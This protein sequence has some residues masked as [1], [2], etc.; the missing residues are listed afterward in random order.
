[1]KCHTLGRVLTVVGLVGAFGA[2]IVCPPVANAD[3]VTLSGVSACAC[4]AVPDSW[5]VTW[6]LTNERTDQAVTVTG[7]SRLVFPIGTSV[8]PGAS[9]Q[10]TE[11]V[12]KPG[13]VPLSVDELWSDQTAGTAAADVL[14]AGTCSATT[15][16]TA[17]TV[18]TTHP[19]PTASPVPTTHPTPTA[20]PVPTTHPT[21]TMHLVPTMPPVSTQTTLP[22]LLIHAV[23]PSPTP[24]PMV[25]KSMSVISRQA[26]RAGTPTD[27][28][29]STGAA[30]RRLSV[31]AVALG[32]AGTLVL[33]ACRRRRG[34]RV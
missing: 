26:T 18:P 8:A 16:T 23:I 31:I 1:M 7:E 10:A 3:T 6:T 5:T 30:A 19:A 34:R 24:S 13:D 28:L 15:P 14:V 25:D 22:R 11:S 32:A 17:P 4:A 27:S 12:S 33:I 21:P 2:V 20:S 9:V 29:A